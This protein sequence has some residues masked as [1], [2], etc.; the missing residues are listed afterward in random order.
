MAEPVRQPIFHTTLLAAYQEA[1][2]P[3]TGASRSAVTAC[4]GGGLEG[5]SP[6]EGAGVDHFNQHP[7]KAI[8]HWQGQQRGEQPEARPLPHQQPAAV[9]GAQA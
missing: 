2:A 1:S 7:G 4:K 5:Q 8:A 3:Q 9:A 6:A